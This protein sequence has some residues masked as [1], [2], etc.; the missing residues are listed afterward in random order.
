MILLSGSKLGDVEH[1]ELETVSVVPPVF[2]IRGF[3]SAAERASIIAAAT[4]AMQEGPSG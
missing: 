2:R 3:L 1:L 4:P